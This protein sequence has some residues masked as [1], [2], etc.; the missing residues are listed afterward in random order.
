M[1]WSGIEQSLWS[2]YKQLTEKSASPYDRF[3][4][5]H[6]PA[7]GHFCLPKWCIP[8]QTSECVPLDAKFCELNDVPDTCV[9]YS[10]S[11]CDE[12]KTKHLGQRRFLSDGDIT[13]LNQMYPIPAWTFTESKITDRRGM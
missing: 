4:I 2:G 8:G 3:S 9:E 11:L 13:T 5:M 10:Q 6:Y 1:N 7:S 12:K